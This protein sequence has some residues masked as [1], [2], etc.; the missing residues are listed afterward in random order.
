MAAN[1]ELSIPTLDIAPYVAW[2]ASL[3]P[4]D[5]D[6]T[7]PPAAAAVVAAW[8]DAYATYG[9]SQVVGHGVADAVIEDAHGLARQF[10]E[11][12]TEDER[13]AV[14]D[15]MIKDRGRGYKRQGVVAVAG[16]GVSADG[17]SSVARPADYAMEYI[18]LCDGRD[19]S[20]GHLV[21]GLNEAIDA[22]FHAMLRL[23]CV[24]MELTALAL[25]LAVGALSV[26]ILT[27]NNLR[28]VDTDRDAGKRTL[29]V[30][31]GAAPARR[32]YALTVFLALAIPVGLWLAGRADAPVLLVLLALPLAAG[33][34]RRVLGGLAGARLNE[35]L[36]GTARLQMAHAALLA[37]GLIV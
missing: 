14:A 29:V 31:M 11:T 22:Y 24:F 25:G 28:D 13:D 3:N 9:F 19:P 6:A 32:Y 12:T 4:G 1:T 35:V 23:N 5:D 34:V 33:P 30:R 27:V 18:A 8:R 17:R 36:A 10:F 37:I 26:A 2:R 21:D 16:A 20:L 7:P 15:E